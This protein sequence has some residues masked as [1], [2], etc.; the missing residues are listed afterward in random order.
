[1]KDSIKKPLIIFWKNMIPLLTTLIG[2]LLG[3]AIGGD[4]AVGTTVGA[5]I[6]TNLY[7]HI[8]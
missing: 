8:V 3:V 4:S 6:G 7:N 2:S 1:M 5:V